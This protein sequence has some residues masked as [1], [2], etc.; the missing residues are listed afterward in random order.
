MPSNET[1]NE[2]T[3]LDEAPKND[4][5]NSAPLLEDQ[6]S[7]LI[8]DFLYDD[9]RRVASFL[10]QFGTYGVLQQVKATE[11]VG[12][13]GTSKTSATAGIDVIT[14]A[15]GGIGLDSTVSDEEKDSAER[16]YDPLWTNARTFLNYLTERE[17]IVRG[18]EK[19]RIGQ[20]V[21]V[22]GELAA[23][24]LGLLKKM[25]EL[26]AVKNSLLVAVA[27][28]NAPQIQ[29][30]NK[31]ERTKAR[32]AKAELPEGM[33]AGFQLMTI[34]PHTI[35][36]S[37]RGQGWNIWSSL[38][39]DSLV[40]NASELLLKHGVGISGTWSML[41]VLDA[42]PNDGDVPMEAYMLEQTLAGASL[43]GLVSEIL[44]NLA[45]MTRLLLGR[46]A[47]SYGMTPLLIFREISA[48]LAAD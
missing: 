20:F 5:D 39:E 34:M 40:M 26:P 7:N 23:I 19:A 25:W 16:T 42:L 2:P 8:F 48:D 35:Q 22:T 21:L 46:P 9:H 6:R 37:I 43:G 44:G 29:P 17:M 1:S 45:P 12:H 18:I 10:A 32:Y 33:E 14:L 28:A 11:S 15:R 27:K 47:G 13:T 4:A 24:D 30:K 36:A 38:R 41:G 3:R 31:A